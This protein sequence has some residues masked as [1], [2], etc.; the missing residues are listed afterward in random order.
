MPIS[1]RWLTKTASLLR[2]QMDRLIRRSKRERFFGKL[3]VQYERM[4]MEERA[5]YRAELRALEGSLSDGL[6]KEDG[7]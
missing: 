1:R 6:D 3:R 7:W 4:G 2:E 5:S